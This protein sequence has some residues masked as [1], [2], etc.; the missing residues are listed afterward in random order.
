MAKL[1]YDEHTFLMDGEPFRILS[2]ALH[3]FRVPRAYWRDRLHKLRLL[4]LNTVET[5]VA[6]NLH[7]PMPG[8]FDFSGDLDLEAFI[9]EAQQEGLY[10]IVRPGP[11]ICAEWE[12]GGLPWWLLCDSNVRL[13]CFNQPYLKAV[14]RFFDELIARIVPLQSTQGGPVIAVQVENEYGSYGND[15]AYLSYLDEGLIRRGVEVLRFTS[16][17]PSDTMLT[18]GTLPEVLKTANFGSKPVPAFY[19]LRQ[20]QPQGPLMCTEFWNGWFDHW[21]EEHHTRDAQ[22]AAQTLDAMMAMGASVNLYMFH[23]GTNFGFMNGANNMDDYQPTINSYDYDSPLT[24]AGDPGEKYWAFR[25]VL[26]KYVPLPE[27]DFPERAPKAAYGEIALTEAATLF[28]NLANLSMP[29]ELT[30]PEPMELLGQGYG[31]IHYAT[32]V[33][34]PREKQKLVLQDVHDRAYIYVNGQFKG[35]Y[36]RDEDSPAI[37]I[38]TPAEGLQLDILVE[39]M[40]RTNYGYRM[41]DRK[42]ITEGVRLDQMFLYH[43]LVHP[44]PMDDLSGLGFAPVKDFTFTTPTFLRGQLHIDGQP[45]D[46]YLKLP[47]FGKG[48]VVVNGRVLSRY[49]NRGPQRTCYLPAPWLRSGDNEIIVFECEGVERLAIQSVDAP[50]LG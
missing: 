23:G 30:T 40:G 17:G 37:Q 32:F 11:Y 34:G 19:K 21:R 29:R 12:F 41:V 22:D 18:G 27:V 36:M 8:E 44:L 48:I 47:G 14:D 49:W 25:Q 28:D 38:E 1:T 35:I 20:H 13:R 4:G 5:Y 31:Y 42:G 16:D 7:E 2:G 45:Q 10:V 9:Q 15:K 3:Y 26:G 50:E 46:T 6:W 24:E 43:F 39:N 33:P